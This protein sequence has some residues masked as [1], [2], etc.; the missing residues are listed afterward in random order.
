MY[1]SKTIDLRRGSA[2]CAKQ[3]HILGDPQLVVSNVKSVA[4]SN[5]SPEDSWDNVCFHALGRG[6][7][8]DWSTFDN[9]ALILLVAGG[10]VAGTL[11]SHGRK[12]IQ[13]D[14]L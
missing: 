7:L 11:A 6:E 13:A 14:G 8:E 2:I 1:Y 5:L 10:A 12:R 9:Y 4:G 3:G